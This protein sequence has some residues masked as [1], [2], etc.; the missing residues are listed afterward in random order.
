MASGMMNFMGFHGGEV[1]IQKQTPTAEAKERMTARPLMNPAGA[2]AELPTILCMGF[3]QPEAVTPLS[4]ARLHTFLWRGWVN[5]CST[6]VSL[7][8]EALLVVRSCQEFSI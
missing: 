8:T 7:T 1:E 3:S 2:R 4:G 6:M 5:L